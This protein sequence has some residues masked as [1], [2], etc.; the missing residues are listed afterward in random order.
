MHQSL[1]MQSFVAQQSHTSG[2]QKRPRAWAADS[3]EACVAG[4]LSRSYTAGD[5]AAAINKPILRDEVLYRAVI[6]ALKSAQR[7]TGFVPTRCLA[8]PSTSA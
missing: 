4:P 1:Y 6:P 7:T 3:E 5:I 8:E 2:Q